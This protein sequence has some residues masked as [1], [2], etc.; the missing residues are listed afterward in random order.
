MGDEEKG[1]ICRNPLLSHS[2]EEMNK[3][4]LLANTISSLCILQH[5]TQNLLLHK[6]SP[7]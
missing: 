3:K 5:T 2:L 4:H 1:Y 6:T 7:G